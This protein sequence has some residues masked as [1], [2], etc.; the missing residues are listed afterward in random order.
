MSTLSEEELSALKPKETVHQMKQ[1]HQQ[2]LKAVPKGAKGKQQAAELETKHDAELKTLQAAWA[3]FRLAESGELPANATPE[4]APDAAKA[5]L[6]A[7]L[8]GGSGEN[9]LYDERT[10]TQSKAAKKK[11]RRQAKEEEETKRMQ[12]EVAKRPDEKK[13][14]DEA[15]QANLKKYTFAGQDEYTVAGAKISPIPADGNCLYHAISHQM[16]VQGGATRLPMKEVRKA[17]ASFIK[18]HYDDFAPYLM[19][20]DGDSMSAAD[21]DTYLTSV[22]NDGSESSQPVVWGGHTEVVAIANAL[23]RRIVIHSGLGK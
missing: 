10:V 14:E 22:S 8:S 9:S 2:A 3:Y 7:T 18:N 12:E 20:E 23:S 21:F 4:P 19:N 5:A 15:L 6:A 11:E 16:G 17:A 1:R 13:R